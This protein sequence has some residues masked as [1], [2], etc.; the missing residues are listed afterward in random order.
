MK[1][2]KNKKNDFFKNNF[3]NVY[4]KLIIIKNLIMNK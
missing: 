4:N 3:L 2:S 1:R